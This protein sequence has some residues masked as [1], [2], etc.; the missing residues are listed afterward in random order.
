MTV[1]FWT[2]GR[3][4]LDAFTIMGANVKTVDDP[5]GQF[6]TGLKYAVAVILRHGGSFRLFI[7]GEEYEFYVA[8][9]EFRGKELQTVRMRKRHGTL[10]KWLSSKQLPFTLNYGRNWQLWQAYRELESNTRDE[11]GR[12]FRTDS[13]HCEV[14][15][16]GTLINVDCPGFEEAVQES[17]TFLDTAPRTKLFSGPMVDIYSGPSNYF[18]YRGI[19]VYELRYPAKLTYDWKHPYVQLTEDRTA[20]NS[21]GLIYSLSQLFQTKIEDSALLRTAL[22]ADENEQSF[23]ASE[24]M[25]DGDSDGSKAFMGLMYQ[26]PGS[27]SSRWGKSLRSYYASYEARQEEE[28][29]S[30]VEL[31]DQTWDELLGLLKA[32][33]EGER[34]DEDDMTTAAKL[35]AMIEKEVSG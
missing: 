18:Y 5:I 14:P 13:E 2:P 7:E 23:E 33:S 35:Y 34:P 10:S 28:P 30:A 21:W 4:P 32:I 19:R 17:E 26:S 16:G 29:S 31:P 24:F 27:A 12:T 9:K 15:D 1:S 25:F 6:G 3:I 20:A 11:R 22:E 8:D